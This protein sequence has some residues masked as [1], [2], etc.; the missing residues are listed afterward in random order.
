MHYIFYI[1]ISFFILGMI[2]PLLF[3]STSCHVLKKKT[4]VLQSRWHHYP[5]L[6]TVCFYN[7]L[8]ICLLRFPWIHSWTQNGVRFTIHY[9]FNPADVTGVTLTDILC[10]AK[11]IL[12]KTLAVQSLE[13]RVERSLISHLNNMSIFF[14]SI[15]LHNKFTTFEFQSTSFGRA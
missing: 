1:S 10:A 7:G 3:M 12:K 9:T 14:S 2:F 8:T 13:F 6:C 5:D 11:S 15:L 4:T